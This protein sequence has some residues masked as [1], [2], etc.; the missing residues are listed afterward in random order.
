[1]I[2]GFRLGSGG[3]QERFD[4]T[5][6]LSIFAKGIAN[7][8]QVAAIVGKGDL[9]D[10]FATGGVLHGGTYNA[11]AISMAATVA[12][13][14]ALT[15]EHYTE[16]SARGVRLREGIIEAL[17][18]AGI[19]AQVVGFRGGRLAGDLGGPERGRLVER[20]AWGTGDPVLDQ[21]EEAGDHDC[22]NGGDAA[23]SA[24]AFHETSPGCSGIRVYRGLSCES[25][26]AG[27]PGTPD[28]AVPWRS[29]E[30]REGPCGGSCPH[31]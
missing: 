26:M 5:P 1:V 22:G 25:G 27:V 15:P 18:D 14:K 29:L 12:V 8:F 9:M 19:V 11:Q 10:M 23:D 21:P 24:H 3:A 16:T 31:S 7:G 28:R 13:Q 17:S 30:R 4:V 6:D 2:T 20:D